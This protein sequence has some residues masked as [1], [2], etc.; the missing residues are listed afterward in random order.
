MRFLI[1]VFA[2]FMTQVSYASL[3]ND[4]VRDQS[5]CLKMKVLRAEI[6]VL[7]SQRDLMQINY[8]LLQSTAIDSMEI[9]DKA[10]ASNPG[11]HVKALRELKLEFQ[12]L[13]NDSNRS[14]ADALKYSNNIKTQ[15][16]QC[17]SNTNPKSGV[18]WDEISDNTWDK[19]YPHCNTTE[20]PYRCKSMHG[21][22]TSLQYFIAAAFAQHESFNQTGLLAKEVGRIAADLQDKGMIKGRHDLV[23]FKNVQKDGSEIQRLA[24]NKDATTFARSQQLTQACMQCHLR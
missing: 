1:I 9:V 6:D 20:N 15:C 13:L 2:I 21:M 8:P 16:L 17:H 22:K 14:N 23:F 4:P 19:I 10:L 12:N 7:D 11:T 24:A 3:C 18:K 5:L